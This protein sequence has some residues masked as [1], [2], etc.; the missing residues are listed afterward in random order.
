M[1]GRLVYEGNPMNWHS[2][3]TSSN[4]IYIFSYFSEDM[5]LILTEKRVHT[6]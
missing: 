5:Q 6:Y 3:L 1:L 2:E 4:Q